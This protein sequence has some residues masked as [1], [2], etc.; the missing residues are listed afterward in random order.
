MAVASSGFAFA[1]LRPAETTEQKQKWGW[2]GKDQ[3]A[4]VELRL[5]TAGSK[6]QASTI[7]TQHEL[8]VAY[9]RSWQEGMGVGRVECIRNCNCQPSTIDV[10]WSDTSTQ[11]QVHRLNVSRHEDCHLRIAVA[12]PGTV[13]IMG[14]MVQTVAGAQ[15]YIP[16][17]LLV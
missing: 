16:L 5:S 3:G 17:E 15:R 4:W 7:A 1:P 12:Q 10:H 8:L 2:L 11:A 9:L 14:L 13:H 6:A